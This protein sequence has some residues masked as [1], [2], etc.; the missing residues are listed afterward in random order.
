M[1]DAH[2]RDGL[3]LENLFDGQCVDQRGPSAVLAFDCSL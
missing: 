3:A 1:D 2:P